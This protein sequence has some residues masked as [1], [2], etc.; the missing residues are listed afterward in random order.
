VLAIRDLGNRSFFRAAA[1]FAAALT[2]LTAT[3]REV[4]AS[5]GCNAVN[6]GGF[7]DS[8]SNG[9]LDNKTIG[10]F[11]VGD[12]V[13]F[14]V[15]FN[16][17][18][19]TWGLFSGNGTTLVPLI[20]V[21]S[22]TYPYTVTGA[23]GD[24]TLRS[25]MIAAI[26]NASVSVTATCT[27]G[28]LSATSISLAS[29]QNP[30]SFGQPVTFTATVT[31]AAPT[32]TVAFFDG[33]AQ[34]GSVTLS[35]SATTLTTSA[36]SVG[37]HS[38]TA[39]YGGDANNNA[40]ISAALAQ[41]VGVS[42]DTI[43]LREMQVSVTPIAA[44]ITGQAISNAVSNAIDAG[45]AFDPVPLSPNGSGF[46]YYFAADPQTQTSASDQKSLEGF[47]ASPDANSNGNGSGGRHA[48]DSFSTLAYAGRFVKAPPAAPAA[49]RRDWLAW[50]DVRGTDF[51]RTTFGN[52]LRGEQ[53]NAIAGLTRRLSP[54]LLVGVLGGLEH[55]DYSS[56]AFNG[57]LR[58]DGWTAGAYLGWRLVPNL[59]FD[60]VGAGSNIFADN[61]A[62]TAGG[63]FTG[64]RWLLAGGV[65]GGYGWQGFA[66]EPSARLYTLWEHENAY[67]DSLGAPQADRNFSTGRASGGVKA[68][69][70][71]A[72]SDTVNLA[73]YAGLY[74]DYY[75]SRD[76]ANTVG[77][78][79]V[80]LLQGVSA[81]VVGGLA[82]TYRGRAQL[83][84]GGE[85][86]GIG[87]DG[88]IWTWRIRGRL[89]F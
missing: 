32:G 87:N 72:W 40:S 35:G 28:P 23:N 22:G 1:I 38:I 88:R 4:L 86:G 10:G 68:S 13:A 46:T 61:V 57:V 19:G 24:T 26:V 29:S 2:V 25:F 48:S 84:A 50:I 36:L 37:N 83:S 3:S 12:Q 53:V 33:G 14:A 15:T 82:A 64:S 5:T 81:R 45:F 65:T 55:F 16:L 73:P 49:P 42:P 74:G 75:F 11:R 60:V 85:Y 44:S 62:G 8:V 21:V 34:I 17:S 77:L 59:R 27:P 63:S 47:L 56:Q 7:S 6:A 9:N 78:T 51:D 52:D 41:S 67:T 58:G 70:P 71:F 30:S 18:G 66:L 79:T 69:Y 54:D 43:K 80:P 76:D 20:P 89:P 31:G 39:R